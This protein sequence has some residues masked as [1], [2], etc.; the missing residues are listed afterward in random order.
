MRQ[1]QAAFQR[2][3]FDEEAALGEMF[4]VDLKTHLNRFMV[5]VRFAGKGEI[6]PAEMKMV[7][8][9]LAKRIYVGSQVLDMGSSGRI[10]KVTKIADS[11]NSNE[12]TRYTISSSL[13]SE[14]V[15][16]HED[17][18]R[19]CIRSQLLFVPEKPEQPKWLSFNKE[20]EGDSYRLT[21]HHAF[22]LFLRD[23]HGL[24]ESA[25]GKGGSGVLD[26]LLSASRNLNKVLSAHGILD[27]TNSVRLDLS[28]LQSALILSLAEIICSGAT[29]SKAEAGT[30][31]MPL[32]W[33]K[34]HLESP[35][36][37]QES[38]H[39]IADRLKEAARQTK[40]SQ[41]RERTRKRGQ[42]H[43]LI[44]D[45]SHSLK[46]VTERGATIALTWLANAAAF[47][48]ILAPRREIS[49]LSIMY[50]LVQ[51]QLDAVPERSGDA[52]RR[53]QALL[54][55]E[56]DNA[57]QFW[58]VKREG[59]RYRPID[60]G[61]LVDVELVENL[62]EEVE[63]DT[64][65]DQAAADDAA[66]IDA[67][68]ES[69]K[70]QQKTT[71]RLLER[72]NA[73][74]EI[75]KR[76]IRGSSQPSLRQS[77]SRRSYWHYRNAA[78]RADALRSRPTAAV[79]TADVWDEAKEK[80]SIESFKKKAELLELAKCLN[81]NGCLICGVTFGSPI[82]STMTI[83]PSDVLT[84]NPNDVEW[85]DGGANYNF[86]SG[87]F[88]VDPQQQQQQQQQQQDQKRGEMT[89]HKVR[90]KR[91]K[92]DQAF[93][94]ALLLTS[95][96]PCPP[97][98]TQ[99]I[100]AHREA[101]LYF[102]NFRELVVTHLCTVRGKCEKWFSARAEA[103]GDVLK[104]ACN[105]L[106]LASEECWGEFRAMRD[107]RAWFNA[108]HDMESWKSGVSRLESLLGTLS[109]K[110]EEVEEIARTT[111]VIQ[112][113]AKTTA[114]APNSS[115]ADTGGDDDA[116]DLPFNVA[117]QYA[118]EHDGFEMQKKKKRSKALKPGSLSREASSAGG[119]NPKAKPKAPA[120]KAR[121]PVRVKAFAAAG[122]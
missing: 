116:A 37:P 67:E 68:H 7:T 11:G 71:E 16:D 30:A 103:S 27:I 60:P 39:S 66:E 119:A 90:R 1:S 57:S 100:K 4:K 6:T 98:H 111:A 81:M 113:E 47:P 78:G 56:T 42:L 91:H 114:K 105:E 38:K 96:I 35:L 24:N 34:W 32:P 99:T 48:M 41:G 44:V 15:D 118:E 13:G 55:E 120:T 102:L 108:T 80:Q 29:F 2:L 112:N 28:S 21:H 12:D 83:N 73:A 121:A 50:E 25:W 93:W 85:G 40:N 84:I 101:S 5:L 110:L 33:Q 46:P 94:R 52:A 45:F 3:I 9:L 69:Y 75:V 79:D 82:Q 62:D 117:E 53:L 63:V 107:Q 97:P 31:C 22:V 115:A 14:H 58:L 86:T 49:P 106:F 104:F 18:G 19:T 87:D 54:S 26:Q 43:D 20:K 92:S 17:D 61:K 23:A 72:H 10:S 122:I 74:A 65:R 59:V 88:S 109:K 70:Q 77:V 76:A 36:I 95:S 8:P 89:E 51:K 64:T